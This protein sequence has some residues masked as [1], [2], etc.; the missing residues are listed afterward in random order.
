MST[1]LSIDLSAKKAD[2]QSRTMRRQHT[3]SAAGRRA[4]R[5]AAIRKDPNRDSKNGRGNN[6]GGPSRT[7][8]RDGT[9]KR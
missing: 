5:L 4:R 1:Q 6:S 9:K 8:K 2:G 3:K 7:E